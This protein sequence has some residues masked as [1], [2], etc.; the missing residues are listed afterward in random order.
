MSENSINYMNIFFKRVLPIL[1]TILALWAIFWLV[2]SS[3][4]ILLPLFVGFLFALIF[5][6]IIHHSSLHLLPP[7]IWAGII[8]IGC[9]ILELLIVG[10]IPY[11]IVD[12][13]S[14]VKN[15]FPSINSLVR[16]FVRRLGEYDIT[17]QSK[18]IIEVLPQI[19]NY[20]SS[21]GEE[22]IV[23]LTFIIQILFYI[24]LA[25]IFGYYLLIYWHEIGKFMARS[26]P[27]PYQRIVMNNISYST[28]VFATFLRGQMI[29]S[30]ILMLYYTA[31]LFIIGLKNGLVIGFITG[32]ISFIPFLGFI[33]ALAI[34]TITA[35]SDWRDGFQILL[36]VWV[37]YGVGHLV[38]N[39]ILIPKL[40]GSSVGLKP[41]VA[42][43]AVLLMGNWFGI[44]GIIFSIPI[45]CIMVHFAKIYWRYYQKTKFYKFGISR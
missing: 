40:V 1:L 18:Q 25:P 9:F 7:P 16:W 5:H 43:L 39:L 34:A 13:I 29:V 21:H 30:L 14:L 44:F 12:G 20:I 31:I 6:P 45:A 35:L 8:M 3:G 36:L 23:N 11:L 10:A 22:I 32:V 37:V 28:Q 38:E 19:T 24:L 26:T 41:A 33:T 27:R 4:V 42:I 15:I 17:I 2:Q